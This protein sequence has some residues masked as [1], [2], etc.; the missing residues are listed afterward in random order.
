M[1]GAAPNPAYRRLGIGLAL[2]LLAACLSE[3]VGPPRLPQVEGA[4]N[5]GSQACL[6][7]H[8]EV[9]ESYDG[10]AHA[11]LLVRGEPDCEICHGG[12]SLHVESRSKKDTLGRRALRS[13]SAADRSATCLACHDNHMPRFLQSAHVEAGVSCWECHPDMLHKRAAAP[14]TLL[15]VRKGWESTS[16]KSDAPLV[17]TGEG[18][19]QARFCFQCHGEVEADF[20]L[21][22]RHPVMQ[23]QIKCTDC[24]NLHEDEVWSTVLGEDEKCVSC[25]TEIGGPFLF[26]HFALEEGCGVCH[27]PH[28]SM[29]DKM[30]T[31]SGNGLCEQCH[32]S[33]NFPLIGAVPH[34]GFLS[35]GA[36]CYDCHFQVHGSN[37]NET[38]MPDPTLWLRGGLVR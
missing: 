28:G 8:E 31:Q 32:F 18:L 16:A 19:R 29:V 6:E 36:R 34:T 23:S 5:V 26:E 33:S 1:P 22:Y 30:L 37:T 38:L 13:L 17:T 24:H 35:S 27:Q 3:R 15:S 14:V 12:G 21:Q 7:C 10:T 2:T 4:T 11:A 20:Q 25:H 9:A